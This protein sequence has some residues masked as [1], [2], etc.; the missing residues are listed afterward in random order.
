MGTSRSAHPTKKNL[1]P[2]TSPKSAGPGLKK[3]KKEKRRKGGGVSSFQVIHEALS[4][5]YPM[6]YHTDVLADLE[7]PVEILAK[8]EM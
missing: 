4:K 6:I 2:A 5:L 8:L 3:K 1:A 7:S